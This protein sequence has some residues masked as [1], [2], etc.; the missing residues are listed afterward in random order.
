MIPFFRLLVALND[1]P[2]QRRAEGKRYPLVPLLHFAVL[3]L[4]AGACSYRR[5]ISFFDQ[6]LPLLNATFEM[7]LK[8][9][10]P[11]NTLRTCC[12]A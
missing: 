7:A 8:R 12:A 11:V 9:A 10:L 2:D 1:V 5:V 4:L 6:Q 3:W